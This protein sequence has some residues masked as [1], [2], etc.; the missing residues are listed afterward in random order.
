ML[1]F[2]ALSCALVLVVSGSAAVSAQTQQP[3]TDANAA[4]AAASP[5]EGVA[6]F[7]PRPL[8][9]PLPKLGVGIKAGTLGIG[10]QVGTSL[11]DRINV[12]G[13]ANFLNYSDSMTQ[14]GV[15]YNGTLALRSLPVFA[16][17][18]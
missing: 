3:S 10:F 4:Q 5:D 8:S 16:G 6:Q 12:R 1:R 2:R 17:E 7:R 15:V 18:P 14:H 13:G 9:N 11:T